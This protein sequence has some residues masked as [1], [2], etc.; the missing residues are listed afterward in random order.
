MSEWVLEPP[1]RAGEIALGMP[2]DV[3]WRLLRGAEGFVSP[4]PGETRSRGF[5][6]YENG[7]TVTIGTDSQD[8]V[9]YVEI[10]RPAHGVTVV[11][12]GISIFGERADDVIEQ[13]AART[14]ILIEEDGFRF[15]APDLLLS[16]WRDMVPDGPQDEDGQYFDSVLMARPGYYG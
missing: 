13:L 9:E 11:F 3:A 5:A 8:R 16:L 6:H 15:V 10:Y 14:R 1:R 12:D 7:L 2:F 4:P